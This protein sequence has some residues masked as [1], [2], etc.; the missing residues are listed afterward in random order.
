MAEV[1]E[2]MNGSGKPESVDFIREIIN[3]D[4]KNG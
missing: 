3:E 4:I 1:S 2:N